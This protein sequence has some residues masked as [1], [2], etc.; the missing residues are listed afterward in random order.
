MLTSD[1]SASEFVTAPKDT[2]DCWTLT[3]LK[4]LQAMEEQDGAPIH[5]ERGLEVWGKNTCMGLWFC[6]V[7]KKK[8]QVDWSC[9][10][11]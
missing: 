1:L 7:S 4:Q 8:K 2:R 3:S 5:V 6:S 10:K 11:L 9:L